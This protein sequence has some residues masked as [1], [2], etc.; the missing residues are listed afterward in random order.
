V[1]NNVLMK[2]IF[3]A[4]N[5]IT[6]PIAL[7]ADSCFIEDIS[8][9]G[10]SSTFVHNILSCSSRVGGQSASVTECLL[11][12]YPSYGNVSVGCLN[13]TTSV[14]V[15]HIGASCLPNCIDKPTT[16]ACVECTPSLVHQWSQ[17]CD[18]GQHAPSFGLTEGYADTSCSGSD[19]SIV[20]SGSHFVSGSLK[21]LHNLPSLQSCIYGLI[22]DYS[23]ISAACKGCA[24]RLEV[25]PSDGKHITSQQCGEM[26]MQTPNNSTICDQCASKLSSAFDSQCLLVQSN[27]SSAVKPALLITLL[28]IA[29]Q[30]I[31]S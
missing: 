19:A 31:W 9:L 21:C 28:T 16:S 11:D 17:T 15:S 29:Y 13:C 18:K 10:S 7:G 20:L 5:G 1:L 12:Y 27:G 24:S 4:L 14:M 23:M 8:I 2:S 3:I 30:L 22:P 6:L 26:C 25:F